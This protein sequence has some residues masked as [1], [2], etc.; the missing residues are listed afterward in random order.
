MHVS[1]SAKSVLWYG[2][3]A[4]VAIFFRKNAGDRFSP[5]FPANAFA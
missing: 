1:A 5:G 2:A 4:N 3:A